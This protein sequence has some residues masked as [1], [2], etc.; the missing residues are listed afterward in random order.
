MTKCSKYI[1]HDMY[2]GNRPCDREAKPLTE[3]PLCSIHLAAKR[4]RE[5]SDIKWKEQRR[6]SAINHEIEILERQIL[7]LVLDH[8]WDKA[9]VPPGLIDLINEVH[10]QRSKL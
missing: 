4:R 6:I 3:P 1:W 9:Y 8:P 5:A 10:N 2:I 7:D